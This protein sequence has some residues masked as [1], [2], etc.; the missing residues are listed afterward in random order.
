[1]EGIAQ[2][3]VSGSEVIGPEFS[4]YC[5]RLIALDLKIDPSIK[6]R[7]AVCARR[8]DIGHHPASEW[9]VDLISF[10]SPENVT[11]DRPCWKMKP[12]VARFV[13]V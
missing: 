8:T 9:P 13:W 4:S 2:Y 6:A 11:R 10:V 7:K 12:L 1:M 3:P 5:E